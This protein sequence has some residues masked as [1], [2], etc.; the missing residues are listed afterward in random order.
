[1]SGTKSH[2]P[3]VQA[4]DALIVAHG[5]PSDPEPAERA[6]AQLTARVQACLPEMRLGS[7]TMA[8]GNRLEEALTSLPT[9]GLVYPL[10]MANGWFVRT[11]LRNRL[12]DGAYRVLPP[13]GLDPA[14]PELAAGLVRASLKSKD[15]Q[16]QQTQLLI[17]AHGSAHGQAAAD[18]ARAFASALSAL[19]PMAKIESGF[20]EQAPFLPEIS[21]EIDAPCL[22]LPFFAMDGDHMKEDVRQGLGDADFA[23]HILPALGQADD[24]PELI[25]NALRAKM[26]EREAA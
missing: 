16:P 21:R 23:G 19:L 3:K 24:I 26:T 25:A 9:D 7:A 18:S 13:L 17:A 11:N 8:N 4:T 22:C 20:V 15:F 12:G 14:L 2:F 1:M 10:F 5:Q 6:L